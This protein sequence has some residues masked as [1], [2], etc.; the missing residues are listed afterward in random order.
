MLLKNKN[1]IWS[2][3]IKK[4]GAMKIVRQGNNKEVINRRKEYFI[5]QGINYK[6]VVSAELKHGNNIKIVNQ[7]QAG[8][9]IKNCDGLITQDKDL[10]LSITVADCL[11]IFIFSPQKQTVAIIHAGW[12]NILQKIAVKA[13]KIMINKFACQASEIIVYFG[14]HIKKCHFSVKKE[15]VDKFINYQGVITKKGGN[16]YIDLAE[17]VRMQLAGQGIKA[18]KIRISAECTYCLK[19]YFS[20]R[21]D[22]AKP[23]QA[24]I[25]YIGR[26]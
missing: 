7:K 15:I 20:Q 11:P 10:F 18:G 21:R 24:M 9:I 25:A 26:R 8:K 14:P 12:R 5:K 13:I 16:Y 22:K 19:K 6:R 2:I 3:S 1:L 17:V 23:I 4:D